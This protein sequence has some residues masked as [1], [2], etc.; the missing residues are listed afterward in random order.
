[1]K[2]AR[3]KNCFVVTGVS[4]LIGQGIVSSL[5]HNNDFQIVGVD[6]KYSQYANKLCSKFIQKPN[7]PENS[8]SYLDFWIKLI[9]DLN[10]SLIFPGISH[11]VNFFS[12][13]YNH[14]ERNGCKIV[15]NNLALISI[16][17]D[18]L[19][20]HQRLNAHGI[21]TIP[22]SITSDWLELEENLGSPPYLIK[23]RNG[24]GSEG[25][26][27]INDRDDLKYWTKKN[28]GNYLLQMVVGDDENE[29]TVGTFGLGEGELLDNIIIM[30]RKLSRA[31]NTVFAEVVD[32]E[33]IELEVRKL[34][35]IFNPIGPTNFQFRLHEGHP[36]LLEINPRFSSSTSLRVSFGYNEPI[37]AVSY[38]IHGIKPKTVEHEKGIIERQW[39]DVRW[40]K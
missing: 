11:D 18:K 3:D 25:V 7:V 19:K 33:I 1:M 2:N 35:K 23:P 29:F 8:P 36:F 4:A 21:Q 39:M 20:F 17:N 27:F 9:D 38:Y 14:F 13:N 16:C 22:T 26:F 5:R 24:E 10:I 30:R 31:G 15:L 34:A 28:K 12:K 6:K 37:M 40:E 32:C